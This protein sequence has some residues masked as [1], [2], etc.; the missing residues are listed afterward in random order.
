[1]M[2]SLRSKILSFVLLI[3]VV[4]SLVFCT[5]VYINMKQALLSSVQSEV[6]HTAADKVS[7][8]TEW[9]SSRQSIVSA[10]LSRFGT[11][12]LKPVLD[13]AQESG[14]FDDLYVGEPGKK[15][16]Q[17]S[18]A[19]LVPPGYDPTGRPWYL[20]ASNSTEA[21]T[22]APYIDAA[23]KRPIITFAKAKR[24]GGNLV[25]VVGGD[26][27][28]QR[29]TD[30]VV[31][32]KLPGDGYAF[33]ITSDGAVIAHPTKDSGLKKI[34]DVIVGYDVTN[35]SKDGS[36][37]SVDI[38]GDTIM[39]GLFP[40]GKTGWLL[41]VVV[42][43]AKATAPVKGL[44]AQMIII[45][46]IGLLVAGLFTY[47]G[48]ARMLAGLMRLRDAMKSVA[49]GHG[50][51][52][53]QLTVQSRDEVGQI[54]EAFNGFVKKLHTMF[55]SV[56]DN[57]KALAADTASLHRETDKI[58]A[59]SRSQANELSAT[60]A[61]IE[62]ITVSINH[63]ADNADATESV[64]E[65]T[66]SYSAA[67]H[68]AM[69]EVAEEVESIMHTVEALQSSM[70]GLS[71]HSEEI[72]GIVAV[73][74][75]IADQTN[76]LALNAAIEAARAGEQGRGFAVVAE[77]VGKLAKRTAS[78]TIEI[79]EMIDRVR[80]RTSQAIEHTTSTNDK[81]VTG[82][83]ISHKA[84]EQI[85]MIR[86]STD[87]IAAKMAQI[88]ESTAEQSSATTE[89]AKSA[90]RINSKAIQTDESIQKVLNTIQDLA[91]RGESL[92][93]LVSQFRL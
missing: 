85:S 38:G 78:A 83:A 56:R 36:L 61:T 86:T 6:Q 55:V 23:T 48:V 30:E 16:T 60:A 58:A 46:I 52:T 54:A 7:F 74:R 49:S 40:V 35:M 19:V 51:L 82:V 87:D 42:P 15:M 4:L 41:G 62:E 53:L 64:I 3:L 32:T 76:L 50:D 20:A 71:T 92:S 10:V 72:K 70:T 81:V 68:K 12:E 5:V 67:S 44:M 66:R 80:E 63:I 89:M 75:E 11:G 39:T 1:M 57:A 34:S 9:V 27:S 65:T 28:L 90:E 13:Q 79:A 2:H 73:I 59:D 93:G 31:Q 84:A 18:K 33:L 45:M 17:F 24:D 21:I 91:K 47:Y 69:T 88:A 77:E 26:V 25:A 14:G 37:R 8:I 43:E 29:V 22:T